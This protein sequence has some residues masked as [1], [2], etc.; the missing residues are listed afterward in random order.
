MTVFIQTSVDSF[1]SVVTFG[2]IRQRQD[3]SS[4]H[5]SLKHQTR[6]FWRSEQYRLQ[7]QS[8]LS[9]VYSRVQGVE[10]KRR[11]NWMD[12]LRKTTKSFTLVRSLGWL[13]RRLA[14]T[15]HAKFTFWSLTLKTNNSELWTDHI[16]QSTYISIIIIISSLLLQ[17]MFLTS[18][19]CVSINQT[20]ARS[21]VTGPK[22]AV[23]HTSPKAG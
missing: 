9:L 20:M 11:A 15:D 8:T 16:P 17:S 18:F 5:P 14:A 19:L 1:H 7:S 21:K 4:S 13:I 3:I 6:V 10:E 2:S 12:G 23:A 22:P